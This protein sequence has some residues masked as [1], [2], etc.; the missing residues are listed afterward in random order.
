MNTG[1]ITGGYPWREP[2][3][4]VNEPLQPSDTQ[5]LHGPSFLGLSDES[6]TGSRYLFEDEPRSHAGL[7]LALFIL[8]VLAGVGYYQ[9][10]QGGLDTAKIRD[11]VQS[12]QQKWLGKLGAQ[13]ASV[14]PPTTAAE[15]PA[16][17]PTAS[18][19]NSGNAQPTGASAASNPVSG[20]NANPAAANSPVAGSN[21]PVPTTGSDTK[22][23]TDASKDSTPAA[24]EATS[25]SNNAA[26]SGPADATDEK[27]PAANSPAGTSANDKVQPGESERRSAAAA[28]SPQPADTNSDLLINTADNYLYGRGVPRDCDRALSY[29]RQASDQ[30]SK[31]MGKLG[32]LYATGNCVPRDLATSYRWFAMALRQDRNNSYLE[33]DLQLIWNQMSPE[34]KQR[35][36]RMSQ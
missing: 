14:T 7:Y 16:A 36:I 13:P 28:A 30:S 10:R 11:S 8:L 17:V 5:N 2:R 20:V 1:S 32:G 22:S 19:P 15:A 23:A 24:S 27:P 35:A 21:R 29:L 31:A 6:T 3:N 26:A 18:Q 34:E 25:K 9:W 12:L 4:D 33:H